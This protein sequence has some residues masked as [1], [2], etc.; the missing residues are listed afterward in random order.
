MYIFCE[1]VSYSGPL[2]ELRDVIWEQKA[3]DT[4]SALWAGLML[5]LLP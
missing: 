5:R 2:L 4:P 3:L 1:E